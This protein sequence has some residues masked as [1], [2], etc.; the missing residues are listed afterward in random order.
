VVLTVHGRTTAVAAAG[1]LLIAGSA[2]LWNGFD[3][4]P[5]RAGKA[6]VAGATALM[7]FS[8]PALVARVLGAEAA[9]LWP[10]LRE[11]GMLG[12]AGSN[13]LGFVL[14]AALYTRLSDAGVLVAAAAAVALN[15]LAETLTLSRAIEAVPPLRWLDRA[16]RPSGVGP[17][18]PGVSV[19][20]EPEG[21]AETA[22][23][24]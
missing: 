9:A 19:A 12:D 8:P 17:P 6:F 7:F 14:G 21:K 18:A 13:L 11:R 16:G 15:V 3:V 23:R 4:A 20:P 22:T 24:R 2:N 1:I 5:G 10:D